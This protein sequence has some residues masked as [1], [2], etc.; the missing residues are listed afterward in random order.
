MKVTSRSF[1]YLGVR[2]A[3]GQRDENFDA[4]ELEHYDAEG[5]H[6]ER[7]L[8]PHRACFRHRLSQ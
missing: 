6:E 5:R 2:N 7:L 8:P 4:V 1:L 3:G